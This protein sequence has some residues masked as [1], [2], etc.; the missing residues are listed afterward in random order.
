MPHHWFHWSQFLIPSGIHANSKNC[1]FPIFFSYA[2]PTWKL[3]Q[4]CA[5]FRYWSRTLIFFSQFLFHV[6]TYFVYVLQFKLEKKKNFGPLY[7]TCTGAA[8]QV[9]TPLVFIV[10]NLFGSNASHG[11]VSHCIHRFLLNIIPSICPKSYVKDYHG[12]ASILHLSIVS[13]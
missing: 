8:N 7:W 2:I 11:S 13:C 10:F 9:S 12:L 5:I 3:Q 1:P 6:S 4:R